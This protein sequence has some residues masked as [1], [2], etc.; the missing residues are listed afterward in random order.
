VP[1]RQ[2]STLLGIAILV[3]W[4][5]VHL[6]FANYRPLDVALAAILLV[7]LVNDVGRRVR[8]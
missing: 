8:R 2:S 7:M 6:R 4:Y 5:G 3:G 1:D